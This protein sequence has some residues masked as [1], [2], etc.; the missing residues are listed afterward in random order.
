MNVK[1][2]DRLCSA[3]GSPCYVMIQTFTHF[4]SKVYCWD[5]V[6]EGFW[7]P[8][9]QLYRAQMLYTEVITESYFVRPLYKGVVIIYGRGA[10]DKGGG[11]IGFDCKQLEGG[12]QNFN[13]QL[14]RGGAKFECPN[15]WVH[16]FGGGGQKCSSWLLRGG[17]RFECE[18]FSEFHRPPAINNDHSLNKQMDLV[19]Y[20][21]LTGVRE[22]TELSDT[23]MPNRL[24]ASIRKARKSCGKALFSGGFLSWNPI[25]CCNFAPCDFLILQIV[26]TWMMMVGV[27]VSMNQYVPKGFLAC[28]RTSNSYLLSL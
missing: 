4:K 10:V 14:Q 19:F 18:R 8:L 1:T 5:L 25:F 3:W 28:S 15:I 9:A 17:A 26:P 6:W 22:V 27:L 7:S 24:F 11:D 12:G 16:R 21:F 2:L 13:A 20:L 23:S